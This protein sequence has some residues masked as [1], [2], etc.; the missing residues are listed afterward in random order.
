MKDNEKYNFLRLDITL[1]RGGY[2]Y[3]DIQELF[4]EPFSTLYP[5]RIGFEWQPAAVG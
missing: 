4:E 5:T 1:N 3:E 2:D